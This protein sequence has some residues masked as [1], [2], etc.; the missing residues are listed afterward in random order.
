MQSVQ[1][2]TKCRLLTADLELLL[3]VLTDDIMVED[4]GEED[5]ELFLGMSTVK[6]NVC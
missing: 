2:L 3:E 1:I 6:C 5:C 4:V